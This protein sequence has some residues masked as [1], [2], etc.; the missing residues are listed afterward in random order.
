MYSVR[1]S[2]FE[3]NSSSTHSLTIDRRPLYNLNDSE[4]EKDE[5]IPY[6]ES[7]VLG[8]KNSSCFINY[9]DSVKIT[10]FRDKLE[11]LIAFLICYYEDKIEY[12][13]FDNLYPKFLKSCHFIWICELLKDKYNINLS[14]REF[15][16]SG[17]QMEDDLFYELQLPMFYP[18]DFKSKIDEIITNPEYVL[19]YINDTW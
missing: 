16:D 19:E 13:D 2:V 5:R 9:T 14:L 15:R 7:I 17:V 8:E 12:Y 6:D 3:T 1:K 11:C 18:D 4:I 10:G